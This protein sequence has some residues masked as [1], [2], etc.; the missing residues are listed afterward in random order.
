[1]NV[2]VGKL[3]PLSRMVN[4]VWRAFM[5]IS[6]WSQLDALAPELTNAGSQNLPECLLPCL[7]GSNNGCRADCRAQTVQW[8]GNPLLFGFF[9]GDVLPWLRVN[10]CPLFMPVSRRA[11]HS[12]AEDSMR[13]I[14]RDGAR[15]EAVFPKAH[16]ASEAA[17]SSVI[18]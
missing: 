15:L 18:R 16:P 6:K 4:P 11:N 12:A 17:N 10:G 5:P 8:R 2:T 3:R 1:M 9:P 14:E 7:A 13:F